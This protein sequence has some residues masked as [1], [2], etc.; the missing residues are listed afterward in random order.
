ML[1]VEDS[2]LGGTLCI[3]FFKISDCLTAMVGVVGVAVT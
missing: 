3:F 1:R 2:F